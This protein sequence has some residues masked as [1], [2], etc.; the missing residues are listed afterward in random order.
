MKNKIKNQNIYL[1][2]LFKFLFLNL[3]SVHCDCYIFKVKLFLN[4]K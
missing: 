3:Y 1:H 2:Y 4:F